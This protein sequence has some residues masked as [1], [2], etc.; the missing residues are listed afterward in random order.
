M[1]H[2]SAPCHHE[3]S[4]W[5]SF[6]GVDHKRRISARARSQSV[7]PSAGEMEEDIDSNAFDEHAELIEKAFSDWIDKGYTARV[8]HTQNLRKDVTAFFKELL[9]QSL[10][11][12]SS[13]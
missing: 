1:L 5:L 3:V 2:G 10:E 7:D 6:S 4:A 13:L 12:G 11:Q 9:L 8:T